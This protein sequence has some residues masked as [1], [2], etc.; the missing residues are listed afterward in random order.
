MI[1][2]R[3][4]LKLSG[5][6]TLVG[7]AISLF[8]WF[9]LFGS[10]LCHAQTQTGYRIPARQDI[11]GGR[12]TGDMWCQYG[13]NGVRFIIGTQT[14][15][16][17]GTVGVLNGTNVT[18]QPSLDFTYGGG[19]LS[20]NFNGFNAVYVAGS[21]V[22]TSGS[23]SGKLDAVGGVGTNNTFN[24]PTLA[25]VGTISASFGANGLVITPAEYASVNNA[26]SELQAQI[27]NA[28]GSI[29]NHGHGGTDTI[30]ITYSNLLGI[31]TYTPI[32]I[33]TFIDSKA[34]AS[35]LASLDANSLVIQNPASGTSTPTASK[36]VMTAAGTTTIGDAWIPPN[37]TRLGTPTTDVISEGSNNKYYTDAKVNSAVGSLAASALSD[38][39]YPTTKGNN[40]VM[41][42]N[43]STG[44]WENKTSTASVDFSGV[45]GSATAAQM[46]ANPT[47]GTTTVS[48]T[49]YV[50]GI[51]GGTVTGALII[52]SGTTGQRPGTPTTG[53][54]RY[55]NSSIG[56]VTGGV[57]TTSGTYT[58][59][60]F[61]SSGSFEV[62]TN[63]GLEVYNGTSWDL[64]QTNP[65]RVDVLVVAGGGGGGGGS[66]GPGGGG[67]G[68]V[69]Y[70]TN[71]K[72][73]SGTLTVVIGAGA[74]GGA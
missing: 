30:K 29:T 59:H 31:G 66:V 64:V 22:S 53:A 34:A 65:L 27:N 60:T 45:T 18:G 54:L 49:L 37:F 17:V 47:F 12:M 42:F 48:G 32:Q 33:D 61:K 26:S 73:N 19:S 20:A 28:T 1:T 52:P 10:G 57:I 6:Y 25:G 11:G 4:L 58:V 15:T 24:S 56:T 43:S 69:I 21:Q 35:G 5:K 13:T 16:Q 68:G 50:S 74:A 55:N 70:S 41:T 44:N 67:G 7:I 40:Q 38:V 39:D 62:V 36:I 51:V 63:G 23:L 3:K 14:V 8:F 2:E 46:P 71:F 72:V 9:V